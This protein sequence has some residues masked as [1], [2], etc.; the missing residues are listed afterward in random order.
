MLAE[1]DEEL[2][3][4]GISLV[5]AEAQRPVRTKLERYE[6]IGPL[7]PG[8]FFPTIDAALEAHCGPAAAER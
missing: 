7:D 2:N 3:T 1:L 6:L 4:D 8:D 5:A